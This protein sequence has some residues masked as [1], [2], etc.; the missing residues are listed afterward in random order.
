VAAVEE[1]PPADVAPPS[2][3]KKEKKKSF[4]ARWDGRE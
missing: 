3:K 4:G 2:V 1:A